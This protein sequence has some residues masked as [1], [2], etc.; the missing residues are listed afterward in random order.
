MRRPPPPDPALVRRR[1]RARRQPRAAFAPDCGPCRLRDALTPSRTRSLAAAPRRRRAVRPFVT[2][3]DGLLVT[4]ADDGIE[5]AA[6][7]TDGDPADLV[8]W[9]ARRRPAGHDRRHGRGHTAREPGARRPR[10]RAPEHGAR[11]RR[12]DRRRAVAR[13]PRAATAV[14]ARRQLNDRRPSAGV[15]PEAGVD[16]GRGRVRRAARTG[17]PPPCPAPRSRAPASA[18][19]ML[20]ALTR[21]EPLGVVERGREGLPSPRPAPGRRCRRSGTRSI[22]RA[23][24]RT[25]S[26]SSAPAP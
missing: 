12:A 3:H 13:R 19:S 10:D 1:A 24:W 25:R 17:R 11:R 22:R 21:T 26:A 9:L 8:T 7:A 18:A 16:P 5:C 23:A 15:D 6:L 20:L 2:V 14:P 4:W